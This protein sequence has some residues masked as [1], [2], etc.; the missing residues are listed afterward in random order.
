MV[1]IG[2]KSYGGHYIAISKRND[3][4]LKFDDDEVRK[5]RSEKRIAEQKAYM[6]V[7]RTRDA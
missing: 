4:W 3:Q 6:L 5:L 7:Y 1:H 2:H